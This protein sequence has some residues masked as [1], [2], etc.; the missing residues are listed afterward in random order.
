MGTLVSEAWYALEGSADM[1]LPPGVPGRGS[2]SRSL[3]TC[4]PRIIPHEEEKFAHKV[5]EQYLYLLLVHILVYCLVA[6]K[7]PIS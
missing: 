6:H 5:R 1:D 3:P 4:M 2:P 7:Y